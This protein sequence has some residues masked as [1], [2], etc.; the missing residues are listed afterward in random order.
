MSYASLFPTV[1]KIFTNLP[2]EYFGIRHSFM[3]RSCHLLMATG[4]TCEEK[5][6]STT[7]SDQLRPQHAV[8]TGK[9]GLLDARIGRAA[10]QVRG[11]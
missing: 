2:N 4:L 7:F 9:S 1:Q 10:N 5:I 8:P 11:V 3:D 6:I